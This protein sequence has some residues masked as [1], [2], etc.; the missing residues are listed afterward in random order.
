MKNVN[1]FLKLL[2]L[3]LVFNS[4]SGQKTKPLPDGV[5]QWFSLRL[6]NTGDRKPIDNYD[7]DAAFFSTDSATV[8]GYLKGYKPSEGFRTGMIYI[9]NEF[10]RADHP[11]VVKILEDGRFEA[12]IPMW[13]PKVVEMVFN[14]RE[15]QYYIEPGQTLGIIIDW[16]LFRKND[17][18]DAIQFYGLL[19]DINI[20]LGNIPL[21]K[22]DDDW[23]AKQVRQ[24]KPQKFK[25]ETLLDWDTQ[26][27]ILDSILAIRRYHEKL[28]ALVHAEL[29]IDML[30]RLYKYTE[31]RKREFREYPHD[32]VLQVPLP[33]NFY[34]FNKEVDFTNNS[35]FISPNFSSFINLT[36]YGPLIKA[37]SLTDTEFLV[38]GLKKVVRLDEMRDSI[39]RNE[40]YLTNGKVYDLIR[41]H[42]L[43]AAF[44]PDL[45][46]VGNDSL[47][48][49]FETVKRGLYNSFYTQQADIIIEDALRKKEGRGIPLPGSYAGA[50]FKKLIAPYAGKMIFVDFWATTCGSSVWDIQ[51]MRA[52]RDKYKDSK[53]F[54]FLFITSEDE[55]SKRVY[56]SFVRKQQ[57]ANTVY[58]S[59]DDYRYLRE[60]FGIYGIPRYAI[61]NKKGEVL[62]SKSEPHEFML[63]INTFNTVVQHSST[64]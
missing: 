8:I 34:D 21:P 51:Q 64:H 52:T 41:L 15:F 13:H 48:T 23:L 60:L 40:L 3:L 11:I 63:E 49:Y 62:N 53:D 32:L 10:S 6:Q 24:V 61:I 4:V 55:S 17:N 27:R 36:E 19:A 29:T 50:L 26:K 57:L 18:D 43:I 14:D 59:S 45:R 35:I 7:D 47:I 2:G 25:G 46:S 42:R 22:I 39:A 38:T 5:E 58:L 44:D 54:V 56:Q 12:R 20:G 37:V 9:E 30:M 1:E 16:P 31:L 28:K 33:A